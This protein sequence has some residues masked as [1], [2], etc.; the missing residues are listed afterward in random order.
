MSEEEKERVF[1]LIDQI[2]A[3]TDLLCAKQYY[4]YLRR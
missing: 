4:N 3:Q 2:N 1:E